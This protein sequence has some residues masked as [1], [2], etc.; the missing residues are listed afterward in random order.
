MVLW[1]LNSEQDILAGIREGDEQ[2][3]KVLYRQNYSMVRKYVISN[4]G[5][6]D[7]VNDVMQD[8]I[9]AFWKN[10]SK[11]DFKLTAKISTYLMAIAKRNWLKKLNKN[12]RNQSHDFQN[13][14]MGIMQDDKKINAMDAAT[15]RTIMNE[16]GETCQQLLSLFYFDGMDNKSIAERLN[17]S[18]TDVVK[19]KKYQCLKKLKIIFEQKYNKEDFIN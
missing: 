16:V 13:N 4:S 8:V 12:T 1:Q 5:T 19:A 9:I 17:F 7:D 6:L 2:M 3:L 10:A 15:F 11:R 18:N 14:D